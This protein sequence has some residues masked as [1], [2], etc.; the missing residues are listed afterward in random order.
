MSL[1]KSNHRRNF[2]MGDCFGGGLRL[3]GLAR[4]GGHLRMDDGHRRE[5]RAIVHRLSRW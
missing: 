4:A 1:S 2:V 3:A 5:H